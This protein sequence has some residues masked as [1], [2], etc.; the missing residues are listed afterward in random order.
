M[1]LFLSDKIY[2]K[3]VSQEF[4]SGRHHRIYLVQAFSFID[5]ETGI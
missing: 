4:R 2:S 5:V 1:S 3:L